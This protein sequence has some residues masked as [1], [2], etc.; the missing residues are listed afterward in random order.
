MRE[1]GPSL[2]GGWPGRN[3]DHRNHL[4]ARA[5]ARGKTYSAPASRGS[6]CWTAEG[7]LDANPFSWYGSR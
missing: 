7:R 2:T 4:S 3:E 5:A 1:E 6:F